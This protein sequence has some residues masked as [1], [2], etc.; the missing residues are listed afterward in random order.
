MHMQYTTMGQ[1]L[2][3]IDDEVVGVSFG[4]DATSEHE[5]GIEPLMVAFGRR[6]YGKPTFTESILR[7]PG[8]RL[9]GIEARRIH[10]CPELRFEDDGHDAI[11]TYGYRGPLD[12]LRGG[13]LRFSDVV[14]KKKDMACAWSDS[15]FGI[16][17]RAEMRPHVLLVKTLLEEKRAA[18][19]LTSQWLCSGLTILDAD[20]FPA[21]VNEAW[22]QKERKSEELLRLWTESGIEQELRKAGK[23]WFSLGHR[24]IED[25][26]GVLRTWLNPTDQR[27][28]SGWYTFDDLRA[29]ARDEGPVA[30]GKDKA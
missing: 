1:D 15:S 25:K 7:K 8:R 29:W 28:L 17:A 23:T 4:A 9:Y 18:L 20:K 14:E 11:L 27:V 10:A 3:V 21:D 22:V 30:R 2:L 24:V 26:H 12:Y 6:Q 5:C 13:H 19:M 16:R